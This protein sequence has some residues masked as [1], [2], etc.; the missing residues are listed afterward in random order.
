MKIYRKWMSF[1]SNPNHSAQK[2]N[3]RIMI[4]VLKKFV[5]MI[6]GNYKGTEKRIFIMYN[7]L[8]LLEMYPFICY[9]LILLMNYE[10]SLCISCFHNWKWI[11]LFVINWFFLSKIKYTC[12]NS[13]THVKNH[14]HMS[15]LNFKCQNLSRH[16][17][18]HIHMS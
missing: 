16:V 10:F 13:N 12:Q 1:C 11:I 15:N 9:Q 6:K 2:S 3:I 4:V 8:S 17:K 5:P 18:N 14:I 7:M